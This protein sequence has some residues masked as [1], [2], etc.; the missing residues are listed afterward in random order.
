MSE[1]FN[2]DDEV[3][4]GDE[5]SAS[6]DAGDTSIPGVD[7][8]LLTQDDPLLRECPSSNDCISHDNVLLANV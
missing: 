3:I 5:C 2:V 4:G 8:N 6:S 1:A 7:D